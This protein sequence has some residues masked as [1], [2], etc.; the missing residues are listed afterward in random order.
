MTP[1]LVKWHDKYASQGLVI[2]QVNDG[3]RD[4]I[5][6]LKDYLRSEGVLFPVLHDTNGS[7]CEGFEVNA[8]P[9][10]YLLDR[11]GTVIWEGHPTIG[12]AELEK[13]VAEAVSKQS[14]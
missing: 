9:A 5:P 11:A 1:H 14:Q 3:L 7:V 6:Q 10:A 13:I 4:S 12:L 8:F 2:L